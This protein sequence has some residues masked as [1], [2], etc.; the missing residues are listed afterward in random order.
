[1]ICNEI[2]E[3]VRS[4]NK[5]LINVF[6]AV[7]APQLPIVHPRMMV[8]ASVTNVSGDFEV[9][10]VLRAPSGHTV[11]KVDGKFTAPDPLSVIDVQFELIGT[12][13]EQLGTYTIDLM[14]GSAYLGGRRFQVIAG[15]QQQLGMS[16]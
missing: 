7:S 1:M 6:N 13:I 9:S 15:W 16:Q 11:F 3:D 14:A 10:L 8:L 5:S 12:P 4:H 2:I